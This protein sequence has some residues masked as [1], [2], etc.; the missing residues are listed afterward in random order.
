MPEFDDDDVVGLHEVDDLVE[1]A[2]ARVGA[3]ASAA[4][5]FVDDGEGEGVGEVDTPA[6]LG[7]SLVMGWDVW[8]RT[9]CYAA[10]SRHGGISC[11]ID[12]LRA[13]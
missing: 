4:D 9:G 7:V 13:L 3:G 6:W 1:A 8:G 10:C 2:F 5:G 12:C 11:K